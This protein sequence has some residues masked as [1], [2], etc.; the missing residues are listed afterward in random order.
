MVKTWYRRFFLAINRVVTFDTYIILRFPEKI[1][2]FRKF[3]ARLTFVG[4][5]RIIINAVDSFQQEG[6]VWL[7]IIVSFFISV[8]ASVIAYYICKWLDGN[9]K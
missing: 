5:C 7:D 4:K 8:A 1:N 9:D 3:S 6:G 2:S